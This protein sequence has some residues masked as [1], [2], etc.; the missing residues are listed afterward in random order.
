MGLAVFIPTSPADHPLITLK[1]ELSKAILMFKVCPI[2][3]IDVIL[4]VDRFYA[5]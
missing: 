4:S 5:E 2:V 3:V 1:A